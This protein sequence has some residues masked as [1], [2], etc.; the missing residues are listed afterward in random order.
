MRRADPKVVVTSAAYL[1]FYRRRSSTPLGG[2]FFEQ[3]IAD[4][5]DITLGSQSP[6]RPSS[7]PPSPSG[8]GKRLDGSSHNGS[9]SALRGVGAVHQR[10]GGGS[11]DATARMRTGIDDEL[12]AYSTIDP[13][14]LQE[15][16]LDNMEMDGDEDEAIAGMHGPFPNNPYSRSPQWSFDQL[17]ETDYG[18]TQLIA[19][20]PASEGDGEDEDLFA[21]NSS[22]KVANSSGS[23]G[24]GNRM[25]DF[26]DDEGTTNGAFGTPPRG[27]TPMLD[28]PLMQD[29]EEPVAEVMIDD[30]DGEPY[31]ID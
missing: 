20:P 9:S 10:G 14:G 21:E 2:P 8:E 3:F 13:R 5:N 18:E 30:M 12:P 17:T 28:V 1:L 25:A 7:R 4:A 6:S 16:T 31:K 26:N 22:T 24:D 19:A 15:E 11:A 27:S 23:D 29:H